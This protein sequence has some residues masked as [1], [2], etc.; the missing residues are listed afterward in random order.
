MRRILSLLLVALL[1]FPAAEALAAKKHAP[2]AS[3][4]A[5]PV[6]VQANATDAS[7]LPDSRIEGVTYVRLE[8]GLGVLV[9]EDDRFPLAHIRM[10]VHAG[11]AYET[12]AQAGIS[13]V[14][15]HM[16]FKGA[17]D[18]KPGE[19]ARRIED[20]GGSL[21]AA[22][23]FDDT[24]YHVEVP[25]AA[26][27]MGLSVVADMTF[28]PSLIP[29]ELKS[30]KEVV[31]AELKRG[32]DTPGSMLFET[33]QGMVF[34]GTSYE[35]PIIGFRDT[36]R[37]ATSESIRQYT[38]PL[39]QPQNMLLCVVGKVKA[40]EVI[41]EAKRLL[42]GIKNTSTLTPPAVFHLQKTGGPRL[43]VVPGMW[44]K[45]RLGLA[46][47][48]PDFRSGKMAGLD[49]L[50][51]IL[52]GDETS[53]LY[54]KFKYEKRLV[55][56]ISVGV[57]NLERGGILVVSAELDADKLPAFWDALTTELATFD[58]NSITD[59]EIKRAR[60]N[61]EAGLFLARETIGGL[62]SKLTQQYA[63]EGGQEAEANYLATLAGMDRNGLG[64]LYREFFRPEALSA[65][66][67]APQGVTIDQ[68]PLLE[69]LK[70][71][72][73]AAAEAKAA[74]QDKGAGAV[75]QISLPG[76]STL[77]LLPDATL[78]YT[79]VSLAW[80]GGDGLLAP[81]EQGL[82]AL[83]A[84]LIGRGTKARTANQVE[85]FLSDRAANIAA[86]TGTE[87]F[88]LSSKFPSRYT[89]DM[90]GLLDE[91]LTRPAF[92]EDE[93]ARAKEDQL[94]AI[95]R[96]EDQPLGLA[97]R[98]LPALLFAS[99]PHD[100]LRLGVPAQVAGFTGAQAA[101]FW[102]RQTARPFVLSVCGS[103]DDAALT[104]FAERLA[105]ELAPAAGPVAAAAPQWKPKATA[106]LHL[107]GRNQAHLFVI[108]K[109]PGRENLDESA[110]LSL[111]RAAL[112][113]QS[114][115]LF[116]DMRDKQG[117]GYTVTAFLWQLKEAGFVAFYIG[118]DPDKLPQALEGFRKAA[119]NLVAT[120]LPKAELD[121][122]K[123]ILTG[124]YY[125]ERQALMA[126]SREAA[127]A[128][129]Q[130]FERDAELKLVERARALT[131]EDVRQAAARVLKWDGASVLTV[132]P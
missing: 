50:A 79:A 47:P 40:A 85:D 87:T 74:A 37:A 105:G 9:K 58:P 2:R 51:Q 107:P 68:A 131:P 121:R 97:F 42:G 27:K 113:G 34:K 64:A 12:R 98:K 28:K 90:L 115:L 38:A 128:L 100:Y 66:V 71:R 125:Q 120:P 44:N 8:N 119:A 109:A 111:L 88:S 102:K 84:S 36:V 20:V 23:S 11:S 32:E 54:R 96:S 75:R 59:Q 124:D 4:P 106:K 94:N 104:A 93:L 62:A 129:V 35:W 41:A 26:W 82:G 126:R 31:L 53:R 81:S 57:S 14:L 117:L 60:T 63:F 24:V 69:T 22:T 56:G 19:A 1:I 29:A 18:M 77:V 6:A 108:F 13:H 55:D 123:N 3:V 72:W 122:A 21:N 65:A 39:Y 25:D 15:E 49:M 52:G 67:L 92:A 43:T 83:T 61:I 127:G 130:G 45:V 5:A 103:F 48:A 110:R 112:A 114:G 16:V 118:S 132:E 78:P 7:P 86:S 116:R 17:G 46:F 101:D 10:L 91:M 73:P 30:E 89:A 70:R 33:L 76:G 95:K 80:T 99:A